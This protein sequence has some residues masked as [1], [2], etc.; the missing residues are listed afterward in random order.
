[1]MLI[2][3]RRDYYHIFD[4]KINGQDLHSITFSFLVH[5]DTISF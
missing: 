2:V 5:V 1:M 4:I 3:S